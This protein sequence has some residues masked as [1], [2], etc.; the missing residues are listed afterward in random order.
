MYCI[1]L[2]L[3]PRDIG[4]P[5]EA[6]FHVRTTH[7]SVIPATTGT[8]DARKIPDLALSIRLWLKAGLAMNS[9]IVKPMPASRAPPA[10]PTRVPGEAQRDRE[11]KHS[12]QAVVDP[13]SQRTD[14]LKC[15]EL[16]AERYLLEILIKMGP[17]GI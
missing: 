13:L 3:I 6:A 7:N 14:G 17:R 5:W 8:T 9:A 2:L 1:C 15:P 12:H 10:S 11:E 4:E 16:K